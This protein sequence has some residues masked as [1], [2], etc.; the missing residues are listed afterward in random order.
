MQK[1]TVA[2]LLVDVLREFGVDAV[3]GIPGGAIA[4]FYDALLERPVAAPAAR[5]RILLSVAWSG[6][7]S[8]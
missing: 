3:F 1:P 8:G 5:T 7:G 6:G 4:G 2:L